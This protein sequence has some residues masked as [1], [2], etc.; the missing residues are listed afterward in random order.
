MT[1]FFK[2]K[3]SIDEDDE[4]ELTIPALEVPNFE[5]IVRPDEIPGLATRDQRLV[6]DL[7]VI[8]QQMAFVVQ[9]VVAGN[10]N[11]RTLECR[12]ARESRWRRRVSGPLGIAG[13]MIAATVPFLIEKVIARF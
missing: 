13:W 8:K 3:R 4:V 1:T 6:L 9:A 7:S 5:P 2:R 12:I 11:D 10:N